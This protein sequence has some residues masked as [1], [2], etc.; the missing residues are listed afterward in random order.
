MMIVAEKAPDV[1]LGFDCRSFGHCVSHISARGVVLI[2][3]RGLVL[4]NNATAQ[5]SVWT[6]ANQ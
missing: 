2:P 6:V 5:Q 1:V 4:N 3:P